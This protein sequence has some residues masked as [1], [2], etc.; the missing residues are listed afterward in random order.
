MN[1]HL[2]DYVDDVINGMFIDH[3]WNELFIVVS[4]SLS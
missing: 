2:I 4:L 3:K 1:E